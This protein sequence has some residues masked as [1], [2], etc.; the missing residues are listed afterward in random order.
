VPRIPGG[1]VGR[2]WFSC[3]VADEQA[4]ISDPAVMRA[5]A[6]PA[7]LA[8]LEHLGMNEAGAT[9]TE[10]AEVVGLSPSATSYHLRALA[11]VGMIIEGT[12]RGDGRERV[13]QRKHT[14]YAVTGKFDANAD[15]IAAEAAMAE[16]ILAHQNDKIRRY[17]SA[18]RDEGEFEWYQVVSITDRTLVLTPAEL[19]DLIEKFD[20]LTEPFERRRRKDPPSDSRNVTL[21][22]RAVPLLSGDVK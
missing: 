19:T 7:R 17:I 14:S 5:L 20:K 3:G 18:G 9:A 8:I 22:L 10:C 6:H 11:K 2:A 15:D 16:S 4:K 12:N 1:A 13:W 21:Q